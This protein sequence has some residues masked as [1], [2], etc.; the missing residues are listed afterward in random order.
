M[1]G[2]TMQNGGVW[3]M[4]ARNDPVENEDVVVWH[5]FG[6]THNPRTEGRL[7]FLPLILVHLARACGYRLEAY[8]HPC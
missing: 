2:T 1:L 8:D 4:A 5:S 6:L 3:D 7:N